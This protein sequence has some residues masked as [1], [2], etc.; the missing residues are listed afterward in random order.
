LLSIAAVSGSALMRCT[1]QSR[2]SVRQAAALPFKGQAAILD[3]DCRMRQTCAIFY[4]RQRYHGQ[5][6]IVDRGGG[7]GVLVRAIPLAAPCPRR[8]FQQDGSREY[9]ALRAMRHSSAARR[10]P[11]GA[12]TVLLLQRAPAAQ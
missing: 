9:G 6:F 3:G 12:R 8:I 11:D 4:V 7:T 5:I 2:R 1:A 10:E